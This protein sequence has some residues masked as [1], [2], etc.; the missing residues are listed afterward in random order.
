MTV[1]DNE[2]RTATLYK[3]FWDGKDASG[4]FVTAGSYDVQIA[5]RDIDAQLA[6][7]ATVQMTIDVDP[8]RIFDV[9]IVPLTLENFAVVSYQISEPM[10]VVTKIFKPGT[11]L[12]D[13]TDDPPGGRLVKRII[14][15][16][17]SRTQISEYWD[18]T[19]LMLSKV[20]DGNY[21]FK[22]YASTF[23][24]AINTIDGVLSATLCPGESCRVPDIVTANIPVTRG[25]TADL[26]GD[27]ANGTFFA[28]NPYD[29]VKGW[30]RI[31]FI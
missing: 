10:K 31:P 22:I 15:V 1:T 8:L 20:P 9:S 25:G 19:D 11:S 5:A 3:D 29:G 18:G 26:C 27:F 23:T 16:R 24:D 6:S 30:F 2:V 7:M 14:G 28:P 17:P 13:D 12:P 4:N 21:I